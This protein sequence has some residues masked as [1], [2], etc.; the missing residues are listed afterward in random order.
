MSCLIFQVFNNFRNRA[1]L[2]AVPDD[3]QMSNESP[4]ISFRW[5]VESCSTTSSAY[6]AIS[7][8]ASLTKNDQSFNINFPSVKSTPL[9]IDQCPAAGK[10]NWI[11]S[12]SECK[13]P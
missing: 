13:V 5:E 1:A 6:S 9:H 8:P 4:K 11:T 2:K 3:D 10:L 12:D 7:M